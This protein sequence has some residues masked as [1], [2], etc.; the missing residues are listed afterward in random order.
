[1]AFKVITNV[2]NGGGTIYN[3]AQAFGQTTPGDDEPLIYDESGDQDPNNYNGSNAGPNSN[4]TTD[5][6]NTTPSD[7]EKGIANPSQGVDS[8]NNNQGSGAE[9]EVNP[10]QINGVST[11]ILNGPKDAP[12]AVGPTSDSTNAKYQNDDFT[13]KAA[14]VTAAESVPGSD[15]DPGEIIFTNTVSNPSSATLSNVLLRPIAPDTATDLPDNTK[16]TIVFG[17]NSGVYTYTQAGGFAF[18]SGTPI[19]IPSIAP[20]V[21]LNYTVKIDLP[22]NTELSTD[23]NRGFPVPIVAFTDDNNN[24]AYDTTDTHNITIDRVYTGYLKL[25]KEARIL[26]ASG[27]QLAPASGYTTDGNVLAP[28]AEPGNI[29]EYRVRYKNISEAPVGS[30]NVTLDANNT[31]ITED[32]AAGNNSWFKP[33]ANPITKDPVFPNQPN[34]SASATQGTITVTVVSGDI[35]VY[36]NNVGVVAPSGSTGADSGNFILQREIK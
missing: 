10:L 1:L 9:G 21:E 30:G 35:K 2:P 25:S 18:T 8:G 14:D 4:I 16:V 23:L 6:F 29:I 17:G 32:G 11:S 15:F 5:D 7:N 28:K 22:D 27:T 19:S 34:G 31:V 36:V 20:G 24:G 26:N 3:L 13:N 12:E 33:V